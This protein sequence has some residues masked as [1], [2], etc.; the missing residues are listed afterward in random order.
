M[1]SS[2]TKDKKMK[3]KDNKNKGQPAE[4]GHLMCVSLCLCE[5]FPAAAR[6]LVQL[7]ARPPDS[8]RRRNS[9][10]EAL[11]WCPGALVRREG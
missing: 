11:P 1:I 9:D 3:R 4:T 7:S 5:C 2:K 8:P 6:I 10:H